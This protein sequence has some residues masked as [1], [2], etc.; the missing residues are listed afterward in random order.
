VEVEPLLNTAATIL[1]PENSL[2]NHHMS[3]INSMSKKHIEKHRQGRRFKQQQQDMQLKQVKG[4]IT[5]QTKTSKS[6]AVQQY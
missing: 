1:Q 2:Q 4:N 6:G 5:I 3:S